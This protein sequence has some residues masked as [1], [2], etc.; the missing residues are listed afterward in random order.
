MADNSHAPGTVTADTHH[1]LSGIGVQFEGGVPKSATQK[2]MSNVSVDCGKKTAVDQNDQGPK[3]TDGQYHDSKVEEGGKNGSSLLPM[4]R[5]LA[6]GS[7]E[8]G[9]VF[10][11]GE[12]EKLLTEKGCVCELQE[13]IELELSDDENEQKG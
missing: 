11:R 1:D 7:S 2:T 8:Q 10:A 9:P 13:S 6:E 4:E 12:A 3:R 5:F